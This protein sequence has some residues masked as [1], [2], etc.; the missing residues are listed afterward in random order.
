MAGNQAVSRLIGGA[1]V[2]R[3][4]AERHPGCPC[5][6][7]E[8]PVQRAD[9]SEFG[10]AE[11]P[12]GAPPA[13]GQGA[14]SGPRTL[15][16]PRFVGDAKLEACLNDR[17]RLGQGDVSEST[18]K[19]QQALID[20][21][22]NLGPTGA[23]MIYGSKTAAAV[24][25][26]KTK[27]NLGFTQFGDVG[28]GTM[29][30]LDEL[31]PG[32]VPECPILGPEPGGGAAPAGGE[33]AT[34][35]EGLAFAGGGAQQVRAGAPVGLAFG[36]PGLLCQIKP[37]DDPIP[38]NIGQVKAATRA[39]LVL[40]TSRRDQASMDAGYQIF[41]GG[42]K[43]SGNLGSTTPIFGDGVTQGT[44]DPDKDIRDGL[45]SV[46]SLLV[47]GKPNGLPVGTTTTLTIGDVPGRN[48]KDGKPI[49]QPGGIFR[50][51]HLQLAQGPHMLMERLGDVSTRAP[52]ATTATTAATFATAFA[53]EGFTLVLT[54]PAG[55]GTPTTSYTAAEIRHLD[56]GLRRHGAG[57][58]ARINGTRFDKSSA[59]Q[60]GTEEG[61]YTPAT[62]TINLVS[63]ALAGTATNP[64]GFTAGQFTLNHEVGHA[65]ADR[66]AAVLPLFAAAA[67][68]TPP[69]TTVGKKNNEENFAECVAL[70]A[71][72]RAQLA[73]MR[74]AIFTLLSTRY[75]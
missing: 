69:L 36:I 50:F 9:L 64:G 51:T 20:L 34:G 45:V 66:D 25:E 61:S 2:Q 44:T 8:Q 47:T 1:V 74:P 10:L 65:L 18:A 53:A 59:S 67:A 4:G 14:G 52:G 7:E 57:T 15:T 12:V 42:V 46:A 37:K 3:C 73:A 19:V 5:A 30:R 63:K 39:A 62:R 27:E 32:E 68:G 48:G 16:S 23:D 17:A 75:P 21:G 6:E 28:P 49:V 33:Q 40:D 38:Q 29:S 11:A 35:G 13:A 71:M 22:H 43:Q 58:L 55:G 26:F 56:Q 41:R 24:R 60:L 54:P 31:F 72:D 70:L